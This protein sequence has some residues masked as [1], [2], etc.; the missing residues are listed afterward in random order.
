MSMEATMDTT[1]QT[2]G[3]GGTMD[4]RCRRCDDDEDETA[5]MCTCSDYRRQHGYPES[6][7]HQTRCPLYSGQ[8]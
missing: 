1:T 5:D 3:C 2:S 8:S 4:T 6:G 7:L